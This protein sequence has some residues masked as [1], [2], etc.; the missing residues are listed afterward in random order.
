MPRASTDATHADHDTL[1]VSAWVAG[2]ADAAERT[3]AE[4][5][6]ETCADCAQLATDLRAIAAALP[7]SAVP[8]RPRDFR[9][10][11]ADL[12]GGG[13]FGSRWS[14]GAVRRALRPAGA[15]LATVGIA[16]L[17]LAGVTGLGAPGQ[18]I[19]STVGSPVSAPAAGSA[20]GYDDRSGGSSGQ[21]GPAASD[22]AGGAPTTA[23]GAPKSS[24]A[25]APEVASTPQPSAATGSPGAD[26]NLDSG[27]LIGPT[28]PLEPPSGPSPLVVG[29][30]GLFA[31]GVVLLVVG[32]LVRRRVDRAS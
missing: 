9:L 7:A 8:A 22:G 18:R 3:R 12:H 20:N 27:A 14:L 10:T 17:L 15:G 4:R 25:L 1:L 29:S 30:V 32:H 28:P 26:R 19:L 6:V 13:R 24:A 31:V 21:A 5:Q 11:D 23:S 2:D 16:G